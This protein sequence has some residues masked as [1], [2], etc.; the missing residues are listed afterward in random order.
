VLTSLTFR[1]RLPADVF[2]RE[3]AAE[4]VAL[5]T[6]LAR[7]GLPPSRVW[8][9]LAEHPGPVGAIAAPVAAMIAH[10]GTAPEGLVAVASARLAE[11]GAPALH[12][13]AVTARVAD[14]TGA[15]VAAAYRGLVD[16]VHEELA[17]AEEREIALSGP[18]TTARVLASL[19]LAG[20][21]LAALIGVNSVAVLLGSTP[22]RCCLVAGGACWFAGRR[23]MARLLRSVEDPR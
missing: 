6:A 4:L 18:R 13:L 12:W 11:G 10:G 17:Q 22:G 1:K 21:G 23:W 16:G 15:P 7:A 20:A 9:H 8:V 19:P 3:D 5:L 14:R 2:A